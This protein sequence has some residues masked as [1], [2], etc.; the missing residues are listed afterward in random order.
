MRFLKIYR[1]ARAPFSFTFCLNVFMPIIQCTEKLRKEMALKDASLAVVQVGEPVLSLWHANLI[2]IARKKCVV[3]VNDKTRFN[4]IVTDVSRVH[5]RELGNIFLSTVYSVLAHEGFTPA[6]CEKIV[7]ENEGM[8]Y[9]KTSS[10]SVLGTMN[11]LVFHYENSILE[12]GGVH[13]H[14]IPEIISRL[15]HMPISAI[16]FFFPVKAMRA[17]LENET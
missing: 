8:R 4:F 16:K 17:A 15:N 10:K 11:E 12:A 6:Q 5:L 7:C 14:E 2:Y 9:S 3:F 13:S 1:T